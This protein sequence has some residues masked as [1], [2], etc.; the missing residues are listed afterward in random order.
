MLNIR[1]AGR[2]TQL[3]DRI[4]EELSSLDLETLFDQ[5]HPGRVYAS[6][7]FKPEEILVGA[8]DLFVILLHKVSRLRTL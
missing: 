3:M 4:R 1:I 8:D 6:C 5:T 2:P 7:L